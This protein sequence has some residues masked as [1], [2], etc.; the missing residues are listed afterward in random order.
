MIGKGIFQKEQVQFSSD[1]CK[2]VG[3]VGYRFILENDNDNVL[4]KK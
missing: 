3:Q 2:I 1:V 4:K